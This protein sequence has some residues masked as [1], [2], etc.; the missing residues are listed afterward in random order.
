MKSTYE[1][2]NIKHMKTHFRRIL[3]L[4]TSLILY[5][6]PPPEFASENVEQLVKP[7]GKGCFQIGSIWI[8]KPN[9]QVHFPAKVNLNNVLIEYAIVGKT[10]KL[11]ESLLSTEVSLTHLHL[12]MLLLDT[13]NLRPKS[14][15]NRL[16]AGQP[17]DIFIRWKTD[18]NEHEERLEDWIVIEKDKQSIAQGMWIYN[19]S[20]I[21]KGRFT[22]LN[23]ESIVAIILDMDAL[24]NNPRTGNEN[25]DIWY[26][27]EAVIPP[28]GTPVTVIFQLQN[29][30][31][32]P[33]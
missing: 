3:P 13:K 16:L 6:D 26:P 29:E 18:E 15:E 30:Y 2:Y 32:I 20:R 33:S 11:H 19:G 27:N 5:A 17:I 10:G 7:I 28:I 1:K 12:A 21:D 4:L 9:R 23:H 25:D 31:K 22:A 8:D 14:A 24:V